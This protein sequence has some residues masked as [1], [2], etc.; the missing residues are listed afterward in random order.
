MIYLTVQELIL[1]EEAILPVNEDGTIDESKVTA[2]LED[3]SGII[4]TYLP[5]LIGEDGTH[6][7]PPPR[8]SDSLKPITRD[9]AVYYL[10]RVNGEEDARKRY[11][12][13]VKLLIALATAGEEGPAPLGDEVSSELIEGISGF[14]RTS[15]VEE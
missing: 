3:A 13:A 6:L 5:D 11:D 14:I 1:R 2:A 10:T 15:A 7:E 12:S 9:L 4:R 8:L